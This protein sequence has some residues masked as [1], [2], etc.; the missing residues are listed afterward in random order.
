V[1]REDEDTKETSIHENLTIDERL[2][3]MELK[4]MNQS[5][6][7]QTQIKEDMHPS[8]LKSSLAFTEDEIHERM[9]YAKDAISKYFDAHDNAF[10]QNKELEAEFVNYLTNPYLKRPFKQVL[11]KIADQDADEQ[12]SLKMI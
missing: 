8:K 12:W 4:S 11:S 3:L 7:Q 5:I 2:A 10:I 9:E 1:T 6:T